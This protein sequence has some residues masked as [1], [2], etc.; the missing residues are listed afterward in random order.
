MPETR[1]RP[2]IRCYS[3]FE[4]FNS[5]FSTGILSKRSLSDQTPSW[6]NLKV[7]HMT[8]WSHVSS[9]FC[10]RACNWYSTNI[11]LSATFI[12]TPKYVSYLLSQLFLFRGAQLFFLHFISVFLVYFTS[13][14][15]RGAF[16]ICFLKGYI[17]HLFFLGVH[18]ISV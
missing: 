1:R 5:N 7:G 15:S 16:L 2:F 9:F 3:T 12:L 17:L 4:N 14:L 11:A 18:F 8:N 10:N 6:G 13:V